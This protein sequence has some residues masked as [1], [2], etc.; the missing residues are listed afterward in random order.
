MGCVKGKLI[1]NPYKCLAC[2]QLGLTCEKS[3]D[4][5]LGTSAYE[6]S[7]GLKLGDHVTCVDVSKRLSDSNTVSQNHPMWNA[8]SAP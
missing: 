3:F 7:V 5:C 8:L 2:K 6:T 1:F 4:A